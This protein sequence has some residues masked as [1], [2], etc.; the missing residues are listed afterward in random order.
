MAHPIQESEEIP[1]AI[2]CLQMLVITQDGL[3]KK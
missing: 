3:K 1:L 2:I